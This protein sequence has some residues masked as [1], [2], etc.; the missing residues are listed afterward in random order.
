M[1]S[2]N[3]LTHPYPVFPLGVAFLE[4]A[5]QREDIPV[6]VWDPL[7]QGE[8]ELARNL[9]WASVIGLS[10]RNVDNVSS[11]HPLAY[12]D[13]Y[14]ALLEDIRARTRAPVI[15]GGS[16][17]SIF[18][19]ELLEELGLHWGL[20]GEAEESM[21]LWL[22]AMAGKRAF[23]EVPG[24][25]YRTEDGIRINPVRTVPAEAIPS[26]RPDRKWI[27]AYLDRGTVMN[28]QTQR[29]CALHCTYCTYPV[30]EGRCYRHRPAADLVG[31]I[32]HL[33]ESG[34]EYVFLTDSVFNTAPRHV[35]AFCRAL[36]E[37]GLRIRWGCFARPRNV[38]P[39]LLDLMAEA[40]LQHLEF[41]SDSFCDATL[42][43]YGKSFRFR[44]ILEASEAASGRRIHVCHY[45]IFGGPGETEATI[46][47]TVENS[48]QLPEAPIFAFSGMRIYPHT[49][50]YREW[51]AGKS[52][53]ELLQPCYYQPP[54]LEDRERDR[55]VREATRGLPNW[56][57]SDHA[58]SAGDL[59][60]QLRERGKQGPLWEYLAISRRLS[61]QNGQSPP[62]P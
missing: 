4:A 58:D 43:A 10:L 3:T 51:G 18:P 47:E 6:R 27:R 17:F 32:R 61:H 21:V 37:D 52:A 48:K 5:L 25:V 38:D 26:L 62:I 19:G 28:V 56:I 1:V 53:R 2:A 16:A 36:L 54:G 12:V 59:T 35:E 23:T 24:L 22:E 39:G 40:G 8:A 50:L 44:D 31:E 34:V 7:V 46:R 57:L 60:R 11:S 14:K 20:L 33:K 55:L 9:A 29:G 42:R 30:I 49:P 13:D 41:G 15:A 45:V